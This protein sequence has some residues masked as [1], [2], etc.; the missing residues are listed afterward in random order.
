MSLYFL[1]LTLL[2]EHHKHIEL[3]KQAHS[4]ILTMRVKEFWYWITEPLFRFFVKFKVQPNTI[5]LIG[6]ALT[7]ISAFFFAKGD[8]ATAG[9]IYVIAGSM[10]FFDGRVARHFR[11]SSDAGAFFD[12]VFDRFGESILFL[13]LLVFYKDGIMFYITFLAFIASILISYTKAKGETM[14]VSCSLGLAQR[15]ERIAY[16]G[17]FAIIWPMFWLGFE[18]WFPFLPYDLGVR[19]GVLLIMVLGFH[20]AYIRFE[21]IRKE[22]KALKKSR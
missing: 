1:H 6:F 14:G 3:R 19:F 16:I 21:H 15:P 12:A 2:K 18:P 13:G 8:F 7:V 10:D 4:K 11:K 20:T 5:S 9:W 22:L 17:G